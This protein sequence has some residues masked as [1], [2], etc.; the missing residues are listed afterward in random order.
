[1]ADA[2]KELFDLFDDLEAEAGALAHRERLEEVADRSRSAY[3]EVTLLSRFMASLGDEVRIDVEGLGVIAGPLARVGTG[4]CQV[5]TPGGAW[6][7]RTAAVTRLR[8]V[9]PRSV[10]EV[11]WRAVD[12]LGYASVLR[13]L[14]DGRS[15]VGFRLTDGSSV[16]GVVWRI[17][18]D[19]VELE[20]ASGGCELL[21]TE[22]VAAH[23]EA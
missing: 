17:G 8:G 20:T 14:A 6:V 21:V 22:R 12:R 18:A 9:S 16:D 11:A 13:R 3:H 1:M 19:F 15:Q 5:A 23:R 7:V 2:E 10:P 4:W